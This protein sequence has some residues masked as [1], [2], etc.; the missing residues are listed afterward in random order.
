M[1][2]AVISLKG[3][4]KSYG[5][6]NVLNGVSLEIN[7]GDI[8]GLIGRNGAG[9]TTIF[10]IILGI[11][12]FQEGSMELLGE[13]K[14]FDKARARM[15]FL[16]GS[17][18]FDYMSAKANLEYYR[19][20]KGIKDKSEPERVLKLVGLEGVKKPVKSF[21]L[22]MKQ[23][24][25]IANAIMGNPEVLILDEPTNG[26]DP[27]GIA[28]IRNLVQKINA[29][30]GTTIIISS[31]ILGELQHTAHRFGIINNG[32][33][34]RVITQEE[35]VKRQNAVRINVDDLEKAKTALK[36]AGVNILEERL[37][38]QSLEDFYFAL[39]GGEKHD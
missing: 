26:L 15:G 16:I 33:V 25:G 34:P 20:L 38:E 27:Q 3:I 11:S 4:E 2:E 36:E 13:T 6:H 28:D 10:K 1:S 29:E 39:V 35:L 22:G 14:N 19:Q 17:G 12:G 7:K 9:K 30:L 18:Y 37:E 24:L 5:K 32:T 23:R 31:H 21:S 8:F